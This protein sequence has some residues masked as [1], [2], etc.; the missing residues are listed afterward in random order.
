M[1]ETTT[2]TASAVLEL[3]GPRL[4]ST[5][6]LRR[7]SVGRALPLLTALAGGMLAPTSPAAG[8]VVP[9]DEANYRLFVGGSP[10]GQEHITIHRLGLGQDARILGQSEISLDDGTQMRPRIEAGTD[11]RASSYQNEFTGSEAG[12]VV[13]SRVG[14]RLVARTRSAAGESQREY[15]ASDRTVILEPRVILLY[16]FLQPWAGSDTDLT[17]LDPRVGSRE[18]LTLR[19][20]GP[21]EVRVGRNPVQARHL[22]LEGPDARMDV[23]MDEEGR[24]LRLEVP[25]A[26]FRAERLPG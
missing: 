23:W 17:V 7:G 1:T 20:M 16:Y 22:R 10:V 14:R 21:E 12:E 8:Q 13:V 9:L 15:P 2:L 25:G 11:L 5:S 6:P 18:T 4:P 26:D 24:V 19:L 3:R